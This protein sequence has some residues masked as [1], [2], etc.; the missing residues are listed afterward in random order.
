MFARE[1]Q[2]HFNFR[3]GPFEYFNGSHEYW[4]TLQLNK[5]LGQITIETRSA[6]SSGDYN[7]A[8]CMET[9][10]NSE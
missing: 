4:Y 8:M 2:N 9:Q 7:I 6:S 10:I 1:H 5:L 3:N